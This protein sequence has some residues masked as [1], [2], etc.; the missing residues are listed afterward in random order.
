MN[1]A[2]LN[3]LDFENIGSWP[4]SAR[5]MAVVFLFI[6]AL[7]S[8]YYF[9]LQ[10]EWA[11]LESEAAK[12]PALKTRYQFKYNQTA[13]VPAMKKQLEE[14]EGTF[15]AMLQQLPRSVDVAS[16]LA[17]ISNAG[18]A[19][20]LTFQSITPQEEEFKDFYAELPIEIKLQ[21]DYHQFGRFVSRLSALP[22]IVTLHEI[23]I[24][25]DSETGVTLNMQ[26]IAKTY[27]YVESD[28]DGG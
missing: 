11:R 27:W 15:D 22:R 26:A 4:S 9:Y 21:G 28:G 18:L 12:E 16:L 10:D 23:R 25:P 17:D 5:L 20:G 13:V 3:D 8:G 24:A 19:E 7:G 14:G 6:I 1:L 2:E